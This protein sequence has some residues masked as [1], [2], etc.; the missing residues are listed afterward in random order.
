MTTY[1]DLTYY[2]ETYKGAVLDAASFDLYAGIATHT[3][4][5]YT[6]NRVD[7]NNIPD[8]V[9]KCCCELSE[10]YYKSGQEDTKG[11]ASEKVG[12]YSISYVNPETREKLLNASTVSIIYRWLALT[13]LLYRGCI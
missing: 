11:V 3:I 5:L 7:E 4:K 1:A 12:E 13:G 6:F 10:L 9:K 8:E 2:T